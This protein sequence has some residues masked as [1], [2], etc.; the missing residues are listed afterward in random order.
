[1]KEIVLHAKTMKNFK[2]NY[3]YRT[4]NPSDID[5]NN[6]G[7]SGDLGNNWSNPKG[8]AAENRI[9][10]LGK[11]DSIYDDHTKENLEYEFNLSTKSNARN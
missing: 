5:P 10:S 3:I 7:D 4:V 11:A 1:M 2:P 9:N 8:E 6:R